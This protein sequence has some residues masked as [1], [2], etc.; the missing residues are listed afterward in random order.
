MVLSALS[1]IADRMILLK[2]FLVRMIM[3]VLGIIMYDREVMEE[4]NLRRNFR[5]VPE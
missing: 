2:Y 3:V 1:F 4:I 5:R